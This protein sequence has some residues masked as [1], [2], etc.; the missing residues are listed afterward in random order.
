[1]MPA[2][3]SYRNAM[4]EQAVLQLTLLSC[5][6]VTHSQRNIGSLTLNILSIESSYTWSRWVPRVTRDTEAKGEERNSL[7]TTNSILSSLTVN[8]PDTV[9]LLTI[10]KAIYN[11]HRDTAI[12]P[13]SG[14]GA[15]QCE[16]W[17]VCV[18]FQLKYMAANCFPDPSWT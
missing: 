10:F 1:M 5:N 7:S 12:F 17:S 9:N 14:S 6:A 13:V 2:S 8:G 15:I 4:C 11:L 18:R 3:S 16:L